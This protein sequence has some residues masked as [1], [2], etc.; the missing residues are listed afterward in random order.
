MKAIKDKEGAH[1]RL[2]EARELLMKKGLFH[3]DTEFA[4]KIGERQG[5]LSSAING[6]PKWIIPKI[7]NAIADAFPETVNREYLL[8]GTGTLQLPDPS[9]RPHLPIDIAAGRTDTAI[10]SALETE[11]EA[12]PPIPFVSPYDFTMT[13]TGDSMEPALSH[14]DIIACRW[15]E[16]S[17]LPKPGIIYAFDTTEGALVKTATLRSRT[18]TLHSLNPDYPPV[19]LNASQVRRVARVVASIRSFT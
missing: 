15:L 4:L 13:V 2:L 1:R 7:F 19:R 3:T 10:S 6:D 14:G 9:M 8:E 11:A 12:V 18:F 16:P 5:H 17:A